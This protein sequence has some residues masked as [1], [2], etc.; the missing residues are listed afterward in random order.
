[1]SNAHTT[2][3]RSKQEDNI[4]TSILTGEI[5][6]IKKDQ[7]PRRE[8]DK[9]IGCLGPRLLVDTSCIVLARMLAIPM[10]ANMDTSH[11]YNETSPVNGQLSRSGQSAIK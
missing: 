4:E 11:G 5:R 2:C 6:L 8:N 3:S 9:T 7:P 10:R 1:M